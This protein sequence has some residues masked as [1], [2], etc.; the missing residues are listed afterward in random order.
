MKRSAG[1]L[2][3]S[4][5]GSIPFTPFTLEAPELFKRAR[6]DNPM[7]GA[8]AS[9]QLPPGPGLHNLRQSLEWS[10]LPAILRSWTPNT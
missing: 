10:H 8:V 1:N 6:F 3:R 5:Q 2:H 7:R 4:S 9:K